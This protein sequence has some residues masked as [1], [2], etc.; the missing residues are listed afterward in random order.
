M[1][2]VVVAL[3]TAGVV[4][5]TREAHIARHTVAEYRANA[6]LRRE[7]FMRCL[8]DPGTLGES[9]DCINAREAER[10]ESRGSLRDQPALGLRPHGSR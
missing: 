4:A 3:A 9:A 2:A 10:L 8:N 1:T 5:C 7:V 6:P